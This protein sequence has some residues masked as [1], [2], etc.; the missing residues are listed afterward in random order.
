MNFTL[1]S[2]RYSY[3]T[4]S[5]IPDISS[6]FPLND[7]TPLR[8]MLYDTVHIFKA[9]LLELE[10]QFQATDKDNHLN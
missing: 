6:L 1:I 4:Q 9:E 8:W 7:S 3:F 5:T 10:E 2:Q